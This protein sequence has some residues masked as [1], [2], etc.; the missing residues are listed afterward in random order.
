MLLLTLDYFAPQPSGKSDTRG[1]G[2]KFFMLNLENHPNILH[3]FTK[4]YT[5]NDK[6]CH[7]V[8][9]IETTSIPKQDV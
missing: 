6:F 7:V 9:Y 4:K 1:C 2:T 8:C 3:L 5:G